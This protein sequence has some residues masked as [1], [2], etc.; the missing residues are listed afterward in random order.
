MRILYLDL[1]TL[2]PDHLGCYG[3]IRNTSPNIDRIAAGGMRFERVYCSDAPC[4]PSRAALTTGRFGIHNGVVN[5]G[6]TQADRPSEGPGRGFRDSLTNGGS[7]VN[8]LRSAGLHTCYVGGFGERHSAYW[9]YAGFHEIYDTAHGGMESAEEVT[10]TALDWIERHAQDDNWYLHVNYWDAHTPYRAP[11]DFPNYFADDPLPAWLTAE[12]LAAHRQLAGPHG[13]REVNMYDNRTYPQWPRHPGEVRDLDDWRR[14]IDGYDTGIRY[15]DNH[16]GRLLDA[17]AAR[18]VLDDLV[19]IV[20]SDNGENLGELGIYAEH[21]TA[22]A[23]TCRV[24]LIVRWP[25]TAPEGGVDAGLHYQLDLLP[26]MAEL[27]GK[28]AKAAWDGTAFSGALRGQNQPGRSDLVIS[29]CCHVCQRSVRW[30]HYLYMRTY[31]DGYHLF[32]QE[33][34]YDLASDPH[35]EHNL[36]ATRP[37]LCREGAWRL[38]AWHDAAMASMPPGQTSDPLQVVLA[39]G[40]P[41]HAR[42]FLKGYLERLQTTGRADKA[43]ELRRRHPREL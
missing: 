25:G 1:D 17:L 33:M 40:G 30:E 11:A 7:W 19:I 36:A 5:H 21:A 27:L 41:Y 10:P 16:I 24:P 22:D 20:T 18:G 31:H 29:Q 32:P 43:D 42:G 6:G 23:V 38:M 15:M 8:L 26:T 39:E 4:L 2:R 35:E 14:L 13:A 9:Y 28:P 3:Y 37:D 34:V 12:T